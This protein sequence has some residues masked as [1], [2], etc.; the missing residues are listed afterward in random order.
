MYPEDRVLVGVINRRKDFAAARD[1]GWYRIPVASAPKH[2]DS[3]Y[4]AFFFSRSFKEKNGG[5]H[6]YAKRTGHELVRRRDLLPDE[7]DHANA[8]QWYYRIALGPLQAKIPPILNPTNRPI[9]FIFTTWDRFVAAEAI[10]DLYSTADFY[11]ERVS[12]VLNRAGLDLRSDQL[13]HDDEF[14]QQVREL[15]HRL[16]KLLATPDLE[17]SERAT[18]ALQAAI[19]SLGSVRPLPIPYNGYFSR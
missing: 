9:A 13:W 2:I 16:K 4:L 12:K 5:I 11:A 8:E 15:R 1:H 17:E 3:E 6:Y 18:Q 7:A 14:R 10:A 19:D